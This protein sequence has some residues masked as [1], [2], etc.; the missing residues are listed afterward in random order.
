MEELTFLEGLKERV[1]KD[2]I[3][4]Y[5]RLVFIMV[6]T[7]IF[8]IVDYRFCIGICLCALVYESIRMMQYQESHDRILVELEAPVK[9]IRSINHEKD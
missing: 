6:V 3:M 9:I 2:I 8:C 5:V 1:E 4:Q 7:C